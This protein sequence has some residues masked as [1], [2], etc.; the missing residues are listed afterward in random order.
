MR[1]RVF[2]SSSHKDEFYKNSLETHWLFYKT[3]Q[4][5][6][7]ETGDQVM[8]QLDQINEL[9]SWPDLKN[10]RNIYV[11][12]LYVKKKGSEREQN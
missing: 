1:D 7:L 10:T 4:Y 3:G 2:L 5:Q 8:F 11:K 12:D 9:R 6:D